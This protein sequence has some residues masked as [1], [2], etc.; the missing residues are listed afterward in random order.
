[1]HL[2]SVIAEELSL[3]THTAYTVHT[4]YTIHTNSVHTSYSVRRLHTHCTHSVRCEGTHSVHCE[5]TYTVYSAYWIVCTLFVWIVYDVCTVYAVCVH[6]L[7]SSAMTLYRC[8]CSLILYLWG[9]VHTV[10]IPCTSSGSWAV[11][12]GGWVVVVCTS[13][14]TYV[15]VRTWPTCVVVVVPWLESPS[16]CKYYIITELQAS[17]VMRSQFSSC[18]TF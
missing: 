5:G 8:I 15:T 14:S 11:V 3:C 4:S 6:K 9:Y 16:G 7:S 18:T 12:V 2:Y 17:E 1:M 10:R 13:G